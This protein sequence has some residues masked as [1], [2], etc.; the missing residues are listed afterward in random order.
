MGLLDP[1]QA[2]RLGKMADAQALVVGTV[3][4]AGD[5][6]LVN[7][8]VVSTD[9]A[10]ALAVASEQ[11]ASSSMIALSSDAV[12]LRSRKDALFRSM[13][14]PGWG[15]VYN[16]QELKGAIVAT[17]EAGLLGAALTFH[18]LG[19][20]AESDYTRKTTAEALGSDPAAAAR[21]LRADADQDY[22]L[23]NAF[24]W[25]AGGLWAV[26]VVD[27]YAS[28]VDGEKALSGGIAV[29]PSL[30]AGVVGLAVAGRF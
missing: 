23:R 29:A 14:L 25:A 15:Q 8:R 16:R 17:A 12:V 11:I 21:A 30:G 28:G 24:L 13:L 20:K 7:A 1:R 18:L 19:A 5:R 26:N 27:A 4:L 10:E 22:R 2:P 6:Y 9:T 3:S